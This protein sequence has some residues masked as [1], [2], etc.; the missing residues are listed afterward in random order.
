[1]PSIPK[2]VKTISIEVAR[3]YKVLPLARVGTSL[4]VAM[5]DP[6]NYRALDDLKFITG[7]NI[8]PLRGDEAAIMEAIEFAY[9]APEENSNPGNEDLNSVLAA[10]GEDGDAEDGETITE[11]DEASLAEME[12]AAE[13]APIVK[14]VNTI[15]REAVQ[16]RASDV[17]WSPTKR[18]TASASA[19]TACWKSS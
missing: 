4:Q 5:V 2:L 8:D 9:N 1:M 7:F 15:L 14:L 6:S 16:A 17:H 10:F 12:A 19:W 18:N 11:E 3:K 13:E